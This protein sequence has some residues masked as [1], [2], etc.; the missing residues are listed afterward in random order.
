MKRTLSTLA[1]G[2][3]MAWGMSAMAADS[4]VGVQSGSG[5]TAEVTQTN[6]GRFVSATS[7]VNQY[8]DR[9]AATV[10]QQNNSLGTIRSTI[11]EQS[12]ANDNTSYTRQQNSSFVDATITHRGSFNQSEIVQT[13]V[14]GGEASIGQAGNGNIGKI[15]QR[16][17]GALTAS[18][19]KNQAGGFF[20]SGHGNRAYIEQSETFNAATIEQNGSLNSYAWINQNMGGSGN[21]GAIT[22]HAVNSDARI[23]QTGNRHD[24]SIYQAGFN[25]KAEIN[26]TGGSIFGGN[27]AEIIQVSSNNTALLNQS[28]VGNDAY[29]FQGGW[30]S[31]TAR[32]NQAT[33][34]NA[35]VTQTG[36]NNSYVL[37]QN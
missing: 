4:A 29:V 19:N 21:E 8:G 3:S 34:G 26:Q 22:Q 12:R 5:N 11:T 23:F 13:V 20:G 30:G 14:V 18:I 35:H 1:L 37:N 2:I 32:L 33:G 27:D 25:N 24:A 6:N 10:R 28:G 9:N 36:F 15:I 16:N 17:G 31:H 7:T